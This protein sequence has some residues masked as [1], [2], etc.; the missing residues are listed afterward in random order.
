MMPRAPRYRYY[1]RS[2][3]RDRYFYTVEKIDHHGKSRYVAGIYRYLSSR[4]MFKLIKQ[5]GFA[6]RYKAS[7]AAK[8]YRDAELASIAAGHQRV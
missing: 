6:K 3:S 5:S 7:D 8:R 1:T 2:G 4:K